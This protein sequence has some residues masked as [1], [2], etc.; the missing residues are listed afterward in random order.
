MSGP[1]AVTADVRYVE[2]RVQIV[3]LHEK[4]PKSDIESSVGPTVVP[5]V[6]VR[7]DPESCSPVPTSSVSRSPPIERAVVLAVVKDAY[8]VE[9]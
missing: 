4:S 6:V 7:V 2:S 3:P 1:I 9:E 8:V 5:S